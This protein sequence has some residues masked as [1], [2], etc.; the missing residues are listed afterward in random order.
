VP[1]C[2]LNYGIKILV[3]KISNSGELQVWRNPAIFA[4]FIPPFFQC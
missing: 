3:F 4:N 2:G 1:K